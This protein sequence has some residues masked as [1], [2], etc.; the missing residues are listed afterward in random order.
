[1]HITIFMGSIDGIAA[2]AIKVYAR[3]PLPEL[4]K[5]KTRREYLFMPDD[6]DKLVEATQLI[7]PLRYSFQK[8]DIQTFLF[9]ESLFLGKILLDYKSDSNRLFAWAWGP[10]SSAYFSKLEDFCSKRKHIF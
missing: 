5:G 2:E 10:G 8:R 7:M 4:L 3:L 6:F 1:M 9:Y